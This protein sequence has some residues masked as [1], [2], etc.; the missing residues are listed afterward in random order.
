M[1][2]PKMY[3]IYN[4]DY[5]RENISNIETEFDREYEKAALDLG[6]IKGKKIG[7]AVGSRG[8]DKICSIVSL[9]VEK[10]KEAGGRPYVFGAMG[11]HGN[12]TAEGQREVLASLGITEENI[13]APILCS[14]DTEEWGSTKEHGF[15][16]YGNVL[17]REFDVVVLINRVKMHTDFEDVTES[18]VLK[19]MAI[20]IGNPRGC[21]N[22]HSLALKYGYGTVI[23]ETAEFMS[24]RLNV[25]FGVMITENAVHELSGIYLR[26]P[27]DFVE[28]EKQLLAKVKK[29]RMK[30]PA[31]KI[32]VL[33]VDEMG[34]NISG[35]GMDTKVI[36]RVFV[37]GQSEPKVPRVTRIVVLHLTEE[38]H[39]N[40][41]GIGLADFSTKEV[42]DQI[43]FAATAKNAVA[44][45]APAQGKIP[46]IEANDREAIEAALATAALDEP[47][48]ARVIRIKNTNN[49][50]KLWV[51]EA[52]YEEL[53][54]N[55]DIELIQ[56]GQELQFDENGHL[57][58]S[59][60]LLKD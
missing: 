45:M 58:D 23:R 55:P 18:G 47:G 56:E 6:R 54:D 48:K 40:A 44:S 11:S 57:E 53:K 25:L 12:G 27:E 24:A 2:F 8:I 16:V 19:M 39:G 1:K 10:I 32:D 20:G 29:E 4:H 3:Q 31:E 22:V 28:T 37:T 7:I 51:S 34:K 15:P 35:S 5:S 41:I 49:I 17:C 43:D 30:L 9:T 38:S 46:C 52:L 33:I 13:G 59:A 21:Q 60:K 14:G 36:G 26:K 42:L 50:E